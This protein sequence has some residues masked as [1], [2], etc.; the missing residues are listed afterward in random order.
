M[1][2]AIKA[3]PMLVIGLVVLAIYLVCLVTVFMI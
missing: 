1:I 2:E 3:H